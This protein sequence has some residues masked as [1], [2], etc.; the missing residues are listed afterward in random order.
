MPHHLIVFF[1]SC[2]RGF[3]LDGAYSANMVHLCWT[4]AE[5]IQFFG[6]LLSHLWDRY[7]VRARKIF[8]KPYRV[9]WCP[10]VSCHL[11]SNNASGEEG[12]RPPSH[13]LY[14]HWEL[15]TTTHLWVQSRGS[16][17]WQRHKLYK[18]AYKTLYKTALYWNICVTFQSA[19]RQKFW[20]LNKQTH[21]N[22]RKTLQ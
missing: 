4:V 9:R 20:Q 3:T 2:K 15:V 13:I 14:H 17:W 7:G 11:N 1:K 10:G 12:I 18:K 6:V 21:H 22:N 5:S 8:L 16:W 19:K